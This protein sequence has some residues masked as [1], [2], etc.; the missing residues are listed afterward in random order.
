MT[1]F[2]SWYGQKYY[3][4]LSNY[5]TTYKNLPRC[6]PHLVLYFS[7]LC[8]INFY[9]LATECISPEEERFAGL[10]LKDTHYG[11]TT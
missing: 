11:N 10:R 5:S 9:P 3:L 2:V 1:S 7:D 6:I 4:Y 8:H